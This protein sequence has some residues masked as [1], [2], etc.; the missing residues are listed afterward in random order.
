M[1]SFIRSALLFILLISLLAVPESASAK[2]R[3]PP[4]PVSEKTQVPPLMY[5]AG[6]NG[7]QQSSDGSWF[8]PSYAPDYLKIED[9]A[10]ADEPDQKMQID[11][12]SVYAPSKYTYENTS[13]SWIEAYG[14][15]K[16][17]TSGDI[18]QPVDL[19]F[20]FPFFEY[21]YNQINVS[22]SGYLTFTNDQQFD[23]IAPIPDPDEPN[24]LIAPHWGPTYFRSNGSAWIKR[25]GLAP[26]RY[27]VIEWQGLQDQESYNNTY[28]FEA[29]LYENGEILM[30]YHDMN[31]ADRRG[32][33]CGIAGIEND[34]GLVGLRT[35]NICQPIFSNTAV[36]I[37]PP[38]PAAGLKIFPTEY[39]GFVAPGSHTDY[40]IVIHNTGTLGEDTYNVTISSPWHAGLYE[41]DGTTPLIDTNFDGKVDTG[42]IDQGDARTIL[43]RIDAPVAASIGKSSTAFLTTHSSASTSVFQTVLIKTAIPGSFGQI[44]LNESGDI[45]NLYLAAPTN[46]K[47]V[48]LSSDGVYAHSPTIT[49]TTDGNLFT[50]WS[51]GACLDGEACTLWASDIHFSLIAPDGHQISTGKLTDN[52]PSTGVLDETNIVTAAAPDGKLGLLWTRSYGWTNDYSDV[53]FMLLNP[54]GTPAS[55]PIKLI[56]GHPAADQYLHQSSLN[57]VATGDN[58]FFLLWDA[59]QPEYSGFYGTIIGSDNQQKRNI[60]LLQMANP[61]KG[62]I[63]TRPNL[64]AITGNR[65]LLTWEY[66]N[67]SYAH[68]VMSTVYNSNMV[69]IMTEKRTDIPGYRLDAIQ[70]KDG[71]I[72]I[73]WTTFSG[74]WDVPKFEISYEFISSLNFR[75]LAGPF[76]L[77]ESPS[78]LRRNYYISIAQNIDGDIVMTWTNWF[79]RQFFYAL[80][81]KNGRLKTRPMVFLYAGEANKILTNLEGSAIAAFSIPQ[82]GD[83]P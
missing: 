19:G 71:R 28:T 59:E 82:G 58:R 63:Y 75:R 7:G 70:L 65:V 80:L 27:A 52:H 53:Y 22:R 66:Y 10:S 74:S 1:K 6:P 36:R 31:Y 60:F 30:Q 45:T 26:Y 11:G 12:D 54:N 5:E 51:E 69:E 40:Q 29:V 9:Q 79:H 47:D 4:H 34:N 77:P 44:Y 15:N 48:K 18:S 2:R 17:D 62:E 61:I 72:L 78:S 67:D 16:I 50:V 49:H 73:A 32:Y 46:P 35:K 64:L 24:N 33:W 38:A 25:G 41:A 56:D 55:E 57:L 43:I 37:N 20:G 83:L 76:T 21:S 39:G 42:P 3:Q 81:D 68:Y 14:I 23:S 13:F 8:M